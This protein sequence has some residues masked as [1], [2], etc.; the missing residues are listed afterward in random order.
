M[1]KVSYRTTDG[2][3][4]GGLEGIRFTVIEAGCV[5]DFDYQG[6]AERGTQAALRLLYELTAADGRTWQ[7]DQHYTAGPS[8]RYQAS[9]D[10]NFIEPL[11]ETKK[12]AG[13]NK[14][15]NL[16]LFAQALE[17]ADADLYERFCDQGAEVLIGITGTLGNVVNPV[18]GKPV[19][20]FGSVTNEGSRQATRAARKGNGQ[21]ADVDLDEITAA[22]I[23]DI[24]AEAD[25]PV[26]I[27]TLSKAVMA[28]Q[29]GHP[30]LKAMLQLAMRKSWVTAEDRPWSHNAKKGTIAIGG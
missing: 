2:V 18:S 4:G 22:A 19:P 30:Q 15:S 11:F 27:D 8:T 17:E 21:A 16:F 26:K 28:S 13:L 6:K 7:R 12:D 10:G 25:E 20:V 23:V 9:D 14:S 3:E 1:G 5:S 24:L 29:K